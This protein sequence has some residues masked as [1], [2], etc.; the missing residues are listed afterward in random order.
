MASK[1]HLRQKCC[2]GKVSYETQIEAK[3]TVAKLFKV[4]GKR[5]LNAYR[6][7]FCHKF[8]VGHMPRRLQEAVAR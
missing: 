3:F 5:G 2:K 8:H 6:C 1:R 4:E 7:R